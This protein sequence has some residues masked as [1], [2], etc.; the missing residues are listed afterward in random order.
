M[1]PN[2]HVPEFVHSTEPNPHHGW[3]VVEFLNYQHYTRGVRECEIAV[4]EFFPVLDIMDDGELL[5]GNGDKPVRASV[6]LEEIRA[7]TPY[8]HITYCWCDRTPRVFT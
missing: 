1:T 7:A 6:L 5:V 8:E 2:C 4:R 3:L